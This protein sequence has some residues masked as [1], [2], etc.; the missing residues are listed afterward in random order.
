LDDGCSII[1][2]EEQTIPVKSPIINL[3]NITNPIPLSSYRDKQILLNSKRVILNAF[4]DRIILLGNDGVELYGNGPIILRSNKSG[5][6][7]QD[8]RVFLGPTDKEP[9]QPIVLGNDLKSILSE[10]LVS[11]SNFTVGLA[12]SVSTPEGSPLT[13]IN[14]A[15]TAL[16]IS[17]EKI[18]KDVENKE[19][20]T[21]NK[22]FSQ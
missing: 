17:L 9:T 10:L 5:I 1:L 11:I 8:D 2:S 19:Y 18:I 12:S 15:A 22:V 6:I 20:L 16:Q 14:S 4:E 3:S 13:S 7:L 21:S